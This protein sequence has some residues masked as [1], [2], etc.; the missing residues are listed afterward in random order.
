MP[1]D[2]VSFYRDLPIFS[3]FESVTEL[4]NYTKLPESWHI[5]AAD[6]QD[7]TGAIRDGHY[8]AVNV[9][10]VSVITAITNLTTPHTIPSMFGGDGATLCIPV[11]L[12][13]NTKEALIATRRM[14]IKQFNLNLRI[15]IVPVDVVRRAG[16]EVLLAKHRMSE[17]YTQAAFAGG[18][19]EYAESLIKDD[20]TGKAYRLEDN[21]DSS[22]ADYSGL[23]CRWDNVPSQHG[24]TIALIVK[25]LAP[26]TEQQATLYNEIILKVKQIYGDDDLCRPVYLD[27]LN[28]T[29]N[30]WKLSHELKVRTFFRERSAAIKHWF[31]IRI[32]TFF[33]RI[34]MAFNMKVGGLNWGDYK[35]DVV[36]NTDFKKFDGTLREVISGTSQQREE[37][38]A[39]LSNKYNKRECVYGIHASD[40]ALITCM[41]NN[42]DGEH[43]HFVDSADGGYA[44]AATSMKQQ[45]KSL[46]S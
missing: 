24:E 36:N 26:S 14:A 37:L 6:V 15:G 20:K 3:D 40:S 45:L 12:V 31:F 23:E 11:D 41:I 46:S 8:K 34:F 32:Q 4:A 28:I 10:G 42:R 9:V 30:N 33:G 7:S 19:V 29:R 25:V 27:A 16:H 39:Y 18:G 1:T 2:S 17:H 21:Q 13:P 35:K 5:V 43:Y 22:N 38:D 44:M